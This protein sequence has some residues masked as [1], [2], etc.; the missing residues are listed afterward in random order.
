MSA[1]VKCIDD[2]IRFFADTRLQNS[3]LPEFSEQ[4][5]IVGD[6][7]LLENTGTVKFRVKADRLLGRRSA[8]GG[9]GVTRVDA[10]L[11]DGDN[12]LSS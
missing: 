11:V 3:L 6:L 8:W 12:L 2:P 4:S 9:E 7:S 1:L 10:G 5:P